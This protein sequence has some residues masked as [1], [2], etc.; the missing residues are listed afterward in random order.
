VEAATAREPQPDLTPHAHHPDRDQVVE[1]KTESLPQE[2]PKQARLSDSGKRGSIHNLLSAAGAT[3]DGHD[4]HDEKLKHVL[5]RDLS[6]AVIDEKAQQKKVEIEK[7]GNVKKGYSAKV[8]ADALLLE[9][10]LEEAASNGDSIARIRY[11]LHRW[12][13]GHEFDSAMGIVI[14]LNAVSVGYQLELESS[15]PYAT[16]PDHMKYLE[17]VFVFIYTTELL[18]RYFVYK[19]VAFKS[20]WV[21][22]DSFLVTIA[23]MTI[24]F[25]AAFGMAGLVPGGFFGILRLFRVVRVVRA[26]RL[27]AQ[28]RTLWLLCRGLAASAQ[29]IF[30]TFGLLLLILYIFACVALVIITQDWPM[31]EADQEFDSQVRVYFPDLWTSILTLSQFVMAD[32]MA[33]IYT[34]FG[35]RSKYLM[36]AFFAPLILILSIAVMNLV[37]AVIV[38]ASMEQS[39]TEKDVLQQE[40]INKIKKQIPMIRDVFSSMDADGSGVVTLEEIQSASPE[41]NACIGQ[42]IDADDLTEIFEIIDDDGSGEV[43]IDEFVDGIS[44]IATSGLPIE[45]VRLMKQIALTRRQIDHLGKQV[46]HLLDSHTEVK[47][48]VRDQ[49]LPLNPTERLIRKIMSA[50]DF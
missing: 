38:E 13:S 17:N 20:S 42:V 21:Q 22:F 24:F 40:R 1:Q 41:A 35:L 27:I 4:H 36:I 49:G 18:V 2:T 47:D 14:F 43:G 6:T 16:S 48:A 25:E 37:T 15:E 23:W 7:Q 32:S 46:Q 3:G 8:D 26:F 29:T 39:A 12:M 50:P 9:R 11:T 34:V 5:S 45:T 33:S 10:T 44:K 19:A 28:F 30:Y 31:R